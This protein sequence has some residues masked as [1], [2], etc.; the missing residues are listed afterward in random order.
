M[1]MLGAKYVGTFGCMYADLG[2]SIWKLL[3]ACM[4]IFTHADKGKSEPGGQ[5]RC[6]DRSTRTSRLNSR[7]VT[8]EV[9]H[10]RR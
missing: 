3:G 8:L 2:A 9:I 1:R 4:Q 7:W 5:M 10:M 6:S